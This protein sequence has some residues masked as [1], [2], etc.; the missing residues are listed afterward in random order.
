[1][2]VRGRI[3]LKAYKTKLELIP[4]WTT[5]KADPLQGVGFFVV[6]LVK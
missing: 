6:V 2:F 3:T 4:L 5:Q 1:M